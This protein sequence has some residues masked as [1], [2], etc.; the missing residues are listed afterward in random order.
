MEPHGSQG[1]S[2]SRV[3]QNEGDEYLPGGVRG[4]T[5]GDHEQK[6]SQEGINV[7]GL[8]LIT[9][10][11]GVEGHTLQTA[12]LRTRAVAQELLR[13]VDTGE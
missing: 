5:P 13:L 7:P 11:G 9:Q 3:D 12:R 8:E 1:P 6:R 2:L 4:R 10:V